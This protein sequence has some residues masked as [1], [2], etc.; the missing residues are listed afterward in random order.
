MTTSVDATLMLNINL[1]SV[2]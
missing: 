2:K 1:Y